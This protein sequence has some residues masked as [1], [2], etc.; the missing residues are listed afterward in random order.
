MEHKRIESFRFLTF[1][2]HF[3]QRNGR[4]STDFA[5]FLTHVK[6]FAS[7]KSFLTNHHKPMTFH[8]TML[9]QHLYNVT[10]NNILL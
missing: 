10:P 3:N 7:L 9:F 2:L 5:D 6:N 1:C 8:H 4:D